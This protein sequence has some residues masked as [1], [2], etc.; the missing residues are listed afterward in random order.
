MKATCKFALKDK[1]GKLTKYVGLLDTGSND[2][3]IAEDLVEKYE[4][5]QISDKGT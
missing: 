4:M 3:L 2:S 1:N 5:K